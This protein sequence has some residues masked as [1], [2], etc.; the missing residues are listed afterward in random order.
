MTHILV[1]RSDRILEIELARPGKKN[2][3]TADMYA[4][5]SDALASADADANVHVVFLHGQADLFSSGNDV[6]EFLDPALRER[7]EGQRFVRTIA[8]TRTPIVAAVG[9]V[10]IGVGATLLLHCDIVVASD[11]AQ[12]QFP[13]VTLGLCPEAGSSLVLPQLAGHRRAAALMLLGEPFDAHQGRDAGMVTEVVPTAQLIARGRALATRLAAQPRD[14]LFTTKA[15]LRRPLADVLPGQMDAELVEFE[16]LL[17]G[18]AARETFRAF[19]A[20]RGRGA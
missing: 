11:E 3:I 7:G 5:M 16:R 17:T 13:F 2:A 1:Q 15:L 12:F 6:A 9:G 20:R 14:A 10:A 4:A 8:A 18:D 19:L